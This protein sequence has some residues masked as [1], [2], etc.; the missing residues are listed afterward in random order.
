MRQEP[1][2][3]PSMQDPVNDE[4]SVAATVYHALSARSPTISLL[5]AQSHHLHSRYTLALDKIAVIIV[6]STGNV[7]RQNDD[8]RLFWLYH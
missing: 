2:G 4:N 8:D 5:F 6:H 1:P 3:N 7:S